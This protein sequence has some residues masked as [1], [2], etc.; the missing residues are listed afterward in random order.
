MQRRVVVDARV[1]AFAI[2]HVDIWVDEPPDPP[3]AL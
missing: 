1:G 2:N 3:A